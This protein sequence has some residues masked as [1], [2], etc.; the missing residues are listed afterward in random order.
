VS[1]DGD[2]SAIIFKM[3][4]SFQLVGTCPVGEEVAGPL[5][6]SSGVPTYASSIAVAQYSHFDGSYNGGRYFI[7]HKGISIQEVTAAAEAR[8]HLQLEFGGIIHIYVGSEYAGVVSSLFVE[9]SL[10]YAKR[11][12]YITPQKFKFYRDR[13]QYIHIYGTWA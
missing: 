4:K 11:R 7:I 13:L 1:E 6:T 9:G 2:S 10:G 3:H 12:R 8:C 5:I